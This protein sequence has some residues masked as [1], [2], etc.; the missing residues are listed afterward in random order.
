MKSIIYH[1]TAYEIE[2]DDNDDQDLLRLSW[3]DDTSNSEL[4]K[5][6]YPNEKW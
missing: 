3:M 1:V 5:G 2:D 4:C 6:N